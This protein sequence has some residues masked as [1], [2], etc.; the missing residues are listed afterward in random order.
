MDD[1]RVLLERFNESLKVNDTID[2]M[3]C[4]V[5]MKK[6]DP[7]FVDLMINAMYEDE[8]DEE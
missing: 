2:M 3:E 4:V 8:D 7:A 6:L 5:E 1:V